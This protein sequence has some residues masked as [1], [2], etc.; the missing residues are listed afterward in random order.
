MPNQMLAWDERQERPDLKLDFSILARMRNPTSGEAL[1]ASRSGTPSSASRRPVHVD[2]AC[3][4]DDRFEVTSL[5]EAAIA[6]ATERD[7]TAGLC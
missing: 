6:L 3:F 7:S 5:R 2:R 1:V 4:A